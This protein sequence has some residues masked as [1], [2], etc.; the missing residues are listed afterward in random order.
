[1]E[2]ITYPVILLIGAIKYLQFKRLEMD[3]YYP[4]L[5]LYDFLD[6]ERYDWERKCINGYKN[7][8]FGLQPTKRPSWKEY[9]NTRLERDWH[10]LCKLQ[11]VVSTSLNKDESFFLMDRQLL[12]PRNYKML[13]AK[14]LDPEVI[15]GSY[16]VTNVDDGEGW[17]ARGGLAWWEDE[18]I[19]QYAWE[20]KAI[21]FVQENGNHW[22]VLCGL[23]IQNYKHTVN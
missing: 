13:K 4:S 2:I 16:A 7:D 15:R 23:H 12:T 1:M 8:Y 22:A 11:S 5:C 6:L 21:K 19:N 20:E 17:Y 3:V 18:N 9:V 14:E 10:E